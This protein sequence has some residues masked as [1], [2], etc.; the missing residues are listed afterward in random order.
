MTAHVIAVVGAA[1]GVGTSTVAALVARRRARTDGAPC[2]LVDLAS[3]GGTLDVLLGVEE[4]PGA[5]WS[6]LHRARGSVAPDDLDDRLVGWEG[7][8]V[9]SADR[10]EAGRPAP[11]VVGSVVAALVRRG[12]TVVLDV[13]SAVVGTDRWD[14][15]VGAVGCVLLSTGQDVLGVAA[16]ADVRPRLGGADVRLLLRG[17]RGAQ[18]APAEAAHVLGAPLVAVVPTDRS[19]PQAVDRGL[20]PRTSARGRLARAVARVE[21]R[22]RPGRGRT[23]RVAPWGPV[24][25]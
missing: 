16:A 2:V 8:E 14:A 11:D 3:A 24:R 19:L 7:V 13:P 10:A 5:R 23:R 20:G 17:R 18:V 9:L 12:G 15:V 4:V 6:H 21:E 25:G 22:T 1:G